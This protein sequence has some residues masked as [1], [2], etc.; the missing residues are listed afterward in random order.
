[1]IGFCLACDKP[2][3]GNQRDWCSER[4]RKRYERLSVKY[5]ALSAKRP[6]SEVLVRDSSAF[7]R[8]PSAI[9]VVLVVKYDDNGWGDLNRDMDGWTIKSRFRGELAEIALKWLKKA[10]SRWSFELISIEIHKT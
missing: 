8:V 10:F 2:L 1:M 4:C 3:T 5:P 9:V 6:L 7:V